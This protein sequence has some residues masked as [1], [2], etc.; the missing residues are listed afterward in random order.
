LTK[1]KTI[2]PSTIA[3]ISLYC[4]IIPISVFLLIKFNWKDKLKWVCFLLILSNFSYDLL[5]VNQ[6]KKPLGLGQIIGAEKDATGKT[7]FILNVTSGSVYE[8][9]LIRTDSFNGIIRN[10]T[11]TQGK[12]DN[13]FKVEIETSSPNIRPSAFK[14][15]STLN[16]LNIS[17]LIELILTFLIFYLSFQRFGSRLSKVPLIAIALASLIWVARN[18]ALGNLYTYSNFYNG[19]ITIVIILFALIF[20]YHQLNRPENPFV[21]A[22]PEFWIVSA[23]LVYKA[24]TFFLFLY[25]NTLDQSEKE[26]FFIINSLFYIIENVLFAV[27]FLMQG[28]KLINIKK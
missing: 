12:K 5:S 21:Y 22:S 23:I 25:G 8:G 17:L 9:V 27:A 24:G 14:V 10:I 6:S 15:F 3:D 26:N 28:E 20:F 13:Y 4:C 19:S 1:S 7:N 18:L 16:L 11:A 2:N